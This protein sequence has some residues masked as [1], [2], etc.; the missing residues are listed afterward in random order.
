MEGEGTGREGWENMK[1]LNRKGKGKGRFLQAS[2]LSQLLV[3]PP[4]TTL[5]GNRHVRDIRQ[6]SGR[7]PDGGS[8]A[9][10]RRVLEKGKAPQK[11]L[12]KG[13]GLDVPLEM[14]MVLTEIGAMPAMELGF[15]P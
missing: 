8:V 9:V 14:H 7:K 6:C 4:N 2:T 10:R 13:P 1:G 11:H 5:E 3:R 12:N 15:S